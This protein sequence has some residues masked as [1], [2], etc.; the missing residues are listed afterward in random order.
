[1]ASSERVD[2]GWHALYDANK[3]ALGSDPDHI[4]PGQTLDLGVG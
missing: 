3:S 1:M 2:G 4:V